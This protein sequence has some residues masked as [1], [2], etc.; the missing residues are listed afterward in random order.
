MNVCFCTHRL[1]YP[2]HSGGRA[3][4][5]GLVAGLAD[6][7]HE[8]TLVTYCDD[9]GRAREMESAVG[10]TV[11]TVP[12]VPDRTP[13]NLV[14]NLFTTDPLPIMKARSDS[15]VSAVE[16]CLH[17]A[18]VVHLHALQTAFLTSNID[19]TR[20]TVLR[21]NNVKSDIYRQFARYTGNPVKATYAYLQYVKTRRYEGKIPATSD[22]TLAIT[23][24]DRD[25][26]QRYGAGGRLEVLPAG[27]NPDQFEP[28]PSNPDARRVTFFGSM[29]YHPNEDA[30][31]WL[32]EEVFPRV[33]AQVPDATLELVG[34]GP[35][36]RVRDLAAEDI[37]VTGFVED[38]DEYIDRAS[39]V[40][41]PI[42]VGTGIRMKALH[43]MAKAKPMVTTSVGIQGIAV[44][45]GRH[46]AIADS[47]EAFADAT[48][49]LLSDAERQAEFSRNARQLVE[50]AHDWDGIVGDLEAYYEEVV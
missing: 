20:P 18:D 32:A 26:L 14:E 45:D 35:S 24:E 23:E 31:V 25:R 5:F 48:A 8:V 37:T 38:I 41:I 36:E 33:R 44:E 7:G 22:L 4:T 46:A 9:E 15:Y 13:R 47:T 27:V 16:S 12:G 50:R 10:C 28:S 29:D 17:D 34:K 21:F 2:P 43:A 39:V 11:R 19:S 1:P 6:R 49:A 30:A 3:E 40:V 42:R